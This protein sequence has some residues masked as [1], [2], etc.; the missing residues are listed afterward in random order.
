MLFFM[1][2]YFRVFVINDL[3]LFRFIRNRIWDLCSEVLVNPFPASPVA[4][5]PYIVG[6]LQDNPGAGKY[7]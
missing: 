1:V 4:P 5:F 2:S 6:L 7:H 3:G